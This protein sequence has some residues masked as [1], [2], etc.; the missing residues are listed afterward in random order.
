MLIKKQLKKISRI[1]RQSSTKIEGVFKATHFD[2]LLKKQV[3]TA[4]QDNLSLGKHPE[5]MIRAGMLAQLLQ[6]RSQRDFVGIL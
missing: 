4:Q 3:L 1:L 5:A 6:V 2:R